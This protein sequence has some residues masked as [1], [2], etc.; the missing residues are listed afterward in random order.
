MRG[1]VTTGGCGA[2]LALETRE[3]AHV[4]VGNLIADGAADGIALF[5]A[6]NRV[7][8]NTLLGHGDQGLFVGSLGNA[9]AQPG[10]ARPG[11]PDRRDAGLRRQRLAG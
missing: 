4:I 1:I 10:A 8:R 11:R 3:G 6:G 5:S 9:D 2:A 7:A